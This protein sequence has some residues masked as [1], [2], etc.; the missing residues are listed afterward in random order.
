MFIGRGMADMCK[1]NDLDYAEQIARA[2][3]EEK[4]ELKES[5]G[6]DAGGVD[7]EAEYRK[8]T[9]K[10]FVTGDSVVQ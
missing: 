8:Q 10:D 3:A 1:K 2:E 4:E 6:A 9:G 5:G 7:Y